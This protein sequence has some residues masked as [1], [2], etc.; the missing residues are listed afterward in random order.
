[1][2]NLN[3]KINGT[4]NVQG[5]TKAFGEVQAQVAAANAQL[6]K[7]VNLQNGVD[8]QGFQRMA[9]AAAVNDRAWASAVDSTG[10]FNREQVRVNSATDDYITKLKARKLSFKEMI[11]QQKVATAAY[12]EQLALEN[13]SIR[14]SVQTNA[15]G[16]QTYQTVVPKAVSADMDTAGKRLAFLNEQ[17]RS[18][19]K[20]LVNW[21]K[22]TQWAGRQLTVG[23]TAPILAAGAAAGVMAYQIDKEL[24][25]VAKVYDTVAD[26]NDTSTKGQIALEKELTQVR[27]DGMGT[28]L[29]AA[30]EYGVAATDTL[31]VQADLAATGKTGID[32]QK[33]TAE[34]LRIARLGEIDYQTATQSSIAL[35]S[36]FKM[37]T[38]ELTESFNYMNAVENATSLETADFAAAIPIAAAPVK[39]FGGDVKELGILLTAMKERGI[40]AVQGANAIKASLQRLSRPSKQIQAEF[41]GL[42]GIDITGLVDSSGSLSEIFTKLN[43]A[44]KGLDMAEKRKAFAG[45]FGSYQVTRMT[46]LTEGMG[47]LENGIGQ[48]SDAY[49]ISNQSAQSWADT[50]DREMKRYQ[51]SIS[52]RFETALNEIKIQAASLG[53]PFVEIAT[54]VLKGISGIITAFNALPNFAKIGIAAAIGFTALAGGVLMLTGLFANLIG[55]AM[56]GAAAFAGLFV[57][58]NLANKETRIGALAADMAKSSLISEKTA[59]MQLTAEIEKLTLAQ[60]QANKATLGKKGSTTS[61]NGGL[62]LPSGLQNTPTVDPSKPL[63]SGFGATPSG[64]I[65]PTK[66]REVELQKQKNVLEAKETEIKKTNNKLIAGGVA[67]TTAMAAGMLL[68]STNSEGLANSMGQFLLIAP[69]VIT[70]FSGISSLLGV[71]GPKAMEIAKGITASTAAAG[72]MAG[73]LKAGMGAMVGLISPAGL[74]LAAVTAIGVGAY[75]IWK[76]NEKIRKEQERQNR[77][78]GQLVAQTA[79]WAETQD[80]VNSSYKTFTAMQMETKDATAFDDTVSFYK[81]PEQSEATN[82]FNEMSGTAQQGFLDRKYITLIK[83]V[84]LSAQDA[85]KHMTAFLYAT[86]QGMSDATYQADRLNKTFGNLGN[87]DWMGIVNQG[88][89]DY[90]AQFAAGSFDEAKETGKQV[91]QMFNQGFLSAKTP[92]EAQGYANTLK[93]TVTDQW[94]QLADDMLNSNNTL[95]KATKDLAERGGNA[96]RRAYIDADAEGKEKL[97]TSFTFDGE[98]VAQA[99]DDFVQIGKDVANFEAN[100]VGAKGLSKGLGGNI[101][102]IEQL[103]ASPSFQAPLMDTKEERQEVKKLIQNVLDLKR[104]KDATLAG[105][106]TGGQKLAGFMGIDVDKSVTS[107]LE[108]A[109]KAAFEM[110]NAINLDNGLKKSTNYTEAMAVYMDQTKDEAAG[111]GRNARDIARNTAEAAANAKV[112]AGNFSMTGEEAAGVAQNAMQGVQQ[113]IA[114]E[115]TAD[116]E[117]SMDSAIDKRQSYWDKRAE[118]QQAAFDKENRGMDAKWERKNDSAEKYWDNRVKKI[119]K[120]SEAEQAAEEKRQKMFDNEMDRIKRLNDAMNTNIDFNVALSEGKFDE[121]AKIRND[122]SAAATQNALERAAKSGTGRSQRRVK[123]FDKQKDAVEESRDAYMKRLKKREE[124]ERRHLDKTQKIREKALGR[125][126]EANMAALKKAWE[127]KKKN[128]DEQI[129]LFTSFIARDEKELKKHMRSVGLSYD[130]FGDR[131]KKKGENWSKFF[132]TRMQYHIRKAGLAIKNDKMW[133]AMGKSGAAK[134]LKGMGFSGMSEFRGFINTGKMGLGGGGAGGKSSGGGKGKKDGIYKNPDNGNPTLIGR[135]EGGYVDSGIGSRKGV[136]RTLKGLHPNEQ[137]VRAQKGEYVVNKTAASKH[138]GLLSAI[139]SDSVKMDSSRGNTGNGTGGGPVGPGAGFAGM[140]SAFAARGLVAGT[141]NRMQ[142]EY[143]K[144]QASMAMMNGLFSAGMAGMYGDR[145]FSGEQLANAA[146]IASVGSGMGMSTRDIMIG[147]MTAIAE[148]GLINIH[149]GDRDSQGLFQQRPSQGWGTVAQVT[150]PTYSATKFFEALKGVSGR[151]KLDPWVAAQT[152]Q[153]SAFSDGSNYKPWWDEANAIFNRGLIQSPAYGM[154]PGDRKYS[155]PGVK[156]WV[157][158]A[159]QYLGNKFNIGTIGGVGS[160]GNVSDHPSGHALDFMT[161][162]FSQGDALAAEVVRIHDDLDAT[163][164]IWRQRITSANGG[165]GNWRPMEDRGSPTANHMDHVHLSFERSGDL[166]DLPS[167]GDYG[168]MSP[169]KGAGGLRKP[170]VGGKGW[171]NSHDYRNGIGSPLYAYNDGVVSES[172]AIT[173]GGSPG[174]NKYSTPYRSYG[175]VVKIKGKDGATVTYAHLSPGKRFV[176][177]GQ[178]VKGGALVGLSGDTGNA[179]GPHTH[180]DINGAEISREWFAARGIGL[181][182]GGTIKKDGTPAMLH[183]GERVLTSR[184]TSRLDEGIT[185]INKASKSASGKSRDAVEAVNWS[186]NN[187]SKK[188]K[189]APFKYPDNGSGLADSPYTWF[190]VKALKDAVETKSAP[191]TNTIKTA[192]FNFDNFFGGSRKTEMTDLMSKSDVMGLSDYS[193]GGKGNGKFTDWI[194]GQG[195]DFWNPAGDTPVIWNKDVYKAS[196]KGSLKYPSGRS[197]AT[198]TMNYALLSGGSQP[199]WA[200]STHSAA[201][202]TRAGA[203]GARQR[204][205]QIAQYNK[206]RPRVAKLEKKAPIVLMGDFNEDVRDENTMGKLLP[207]MTSNWANLKNHPKNGGTLG[208]RYIDQMFTSK[209]FKLLGSQLKRNMAGLHGAASLA[210]YTLPS[211]KVGGEVKWDNTIA[212]LHKNEKVLTAPLSKKLDIGLDNFANGAGNKYTVKVTVNGNEAGLDENKIAELAVGKLKAMEKRKPGGRSN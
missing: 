185:N 115:I 98:G 176:Q 130:D 89:A 16:R 3:I 40:G 78:Q 173:S 169:L 155:L 72:G 12:K 114:D 193:G 204:A 126:S 160:R 202:T 50:A 192:T 30:R 180:F 21:G 43:V 79:K 14:Q 191:E 139:N 178:R 26:A 147:I 85:E 96:L 69:L 138:G 174:N 162:N 84:G 70:S 5:I 103:L 4:A 42:T 33:G 86:G 140:I 34:V 29:K 2:S 10:M 73:K 1:M 163:Y 190:D 13:M 167:L 37:S 175:E 150:D 156:P 107:G 81:A 88:L 45:L 119:E 108:E 7:M 90:S 111:A 39:A 200:A 31:A 51:E 93:A 91:A 61:T 144:K 198:G 145:S 80:K 209:E 99:Q 35:Q 65:I 62:I 117:A 113:D 94:D 153:R 95:S 66:T 48:V 24:T 8:G 59:V 92:A 141:A 149:G 28:A 194:K 11:A 76:H 123:A 206:I 168:P 22:N 19:S 25:R 60:A 15:A 87:A 166:G 177:A 195:W 63:P 187:K 71:M 20:Q 148:S 110:I 83:D 116:F 101:R 105:D 186:V 125:E 68:T 128:L 133:E 172:R 52:G 197:G 134:V 75:A 77:L 152:V 122:I 164:A 112:L 18:G 199:F 137:M 102:T 46:A 56:G 82:K 38:Q 189:A 183:A 158:E 64:L 157:N 146:T 188:K 205:L 210:Q 207:G 49:N 136:A 165:W 184:L 23:F 151:D 196:T 154:A 208:N 58:M 131:L 47:D 203:E 170:S 36:V 53:E 181:R 179:S 212:N 44:T 17:F 54:V 124:A 74:V 106:L 211:M 161:S 41:K 201:G 171:S 121:A 120:A 129:E 9:K 27:K 32:L 100:L 6:A 182:K 143:Q 118:N 104:V 109:E 55:S 132:G 142:E 159:A 67:M 97:L 127:L 135:H 57:K